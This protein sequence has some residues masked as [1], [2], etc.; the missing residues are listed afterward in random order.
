MTEYEKIKFDTFKNPKGELTIRFWE[1]LYQTGSIKQKLTNVLN[2]RM[3]K[4]E[5]ADFKRFVRSLK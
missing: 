3:S 2:V 5:L 4:A 1:P